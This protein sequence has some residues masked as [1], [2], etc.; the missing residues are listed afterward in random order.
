[1]HAPVVR[2]A[3]HISFRKYTN[4]HVFYMQTKSHTA[5]FDVLIDSAETAVVL[6]H[7]ARCNHADNFSISMCFINK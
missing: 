6:L 7:G 5:D 3:I 4:K 2:D 1:M